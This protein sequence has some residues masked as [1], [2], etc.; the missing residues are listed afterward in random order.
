MIQRA[1]NV[2]S[3]VLKECQKLINYQLFHGGL[4]V[5]PN[6]TFF[7]A[8]LYISTRLSVTLSLC[9]MGTV[10]RAIAPACLRAVSYDAWGM[11]L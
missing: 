6:A 1:E 4:D 9:S 7:Q 2:I 5:F 11:F 8:I 3:R 10:T